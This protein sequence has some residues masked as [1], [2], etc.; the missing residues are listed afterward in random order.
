MD[1]Y[2]RPADLADR[3]GIGLSTLYERMKEPDFPTRYRLSPQVVVFAESE[4]NEYM[5]TKAEKSGGDHVPA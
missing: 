1:N 5:A 3:L 4:I 2:I